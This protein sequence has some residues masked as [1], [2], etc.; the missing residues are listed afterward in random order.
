M[1]SVDPI[2]VFKQHFKRDDA[3]ALVASTIHHKLVWDR[4]KD[5]SFLQDLIASISLKKEYWTAAHICLLASGCDSQS[6][7]DPALIRNSLLNLLQKGHKRQIVLLSKSLAG[8]PLPLQKNKNMAIGPVILPVR[9]TPTFL[10]RLFAKRL[11]RCFHWFISWL[12]IVKA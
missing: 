9:M 12:K 6:L 10:L 4:L 1:G 2:F 8:Q 3:D 5:D 7:S 11:E